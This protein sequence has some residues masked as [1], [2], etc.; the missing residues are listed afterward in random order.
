MNY[1]VINN[2]DETKHPKTVV[3]WLDILTDFDRFGDENELQVNQM[4]L[5]KSN[6]K[7]W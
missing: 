6:I 3:D 4:Y 5:H 2:I 1:S 7:K